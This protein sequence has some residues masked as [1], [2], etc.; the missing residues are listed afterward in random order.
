MAIIGNPNMIPSFQNDDHQQEFNALFARKAIDYVRLMTIV[1]EEMFP[2]QYYKWENL[3][4]Q[5]VEVI[6]D[7]TQSLIY[8]VDTEFKNNHPEYKTDD[9]ELF[10]PRRSFKES[11]TEAL[12]EAM[13][14]E[15]DA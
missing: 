3:Q 7:I 9:D 14:K 4:G 13:N 5:T 2:T 10:I 15:E 8:D 1:R 12:K 6:R 11:L